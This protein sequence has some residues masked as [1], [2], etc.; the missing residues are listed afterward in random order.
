MNITLPNLSGDQIATLSF[1]G[2]ILLGIAA[3]FR[4]R[5]RPLLKVLRTMGEDWVGVPDRP[6]VKGRPG[7]MARIEQI[8]AIAT[9]ARYHSMPNGGNSAYDKL[10]QKIDD[11]RE[12]LAQVQSD[13]STLLRTL[14]QHTDQLTSFGQR[15]DAS[16]ADR[17]DLH[18]DFAIFKFGRT[19]N[20]HD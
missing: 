7:V 15:M 8:E 16:E 20:H 11:N 5:V 2:G 17:K 14:A 19:E 12:D 3:W 6:G 10:T 1:L 4:K 18:R 9:E 13:V